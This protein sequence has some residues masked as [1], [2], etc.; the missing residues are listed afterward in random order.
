MGHSSMNSNPFGLNQNDNSNFGQG[1]PSLPQPPQHSQTRHQ[2]TEYGFGQNQLPRFI[3]ANEQTQAQRIQPNLPQLPNNVNMN[4]QFDVNFQSQQHP[5]QSY[6]NDKSEFFLRCVSIGN[7][8]FL[9]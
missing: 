6:A 7:G 2:T 3:S 8:F 1:L 4:N 9:N 5:Q